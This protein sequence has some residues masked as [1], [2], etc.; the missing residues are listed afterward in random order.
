M[1]I[2]IN[3]DID[4]DELED[5]PLFLSEI[6]LLRSYSL[7]FL[8]LLRSS[9]L[10]KRWSYEPSIKKQQVEIPEIFFKVMKKAVEANKAKE[11][12]R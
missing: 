7:R 8:F 11:K 2:L 9:S 6:F 5:D 1:G 4:D 12:T 3:T 10:I